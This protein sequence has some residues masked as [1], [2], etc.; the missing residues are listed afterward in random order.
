MRSS[1]RLIGCVVAAGVASVSADVVAPR[2]IL[3]APHAL[4]SD[5]TPD[6]AVPAE[7]TWHR[8]VHAGSTSVP[9][10]DVLITATLAR[11]PRLPKPAHVL[12]IPQ[13]VSIMASTEL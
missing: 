9:S 7:L 3:P 4:C 13:D 5:P 11:W 8:P 1:N 6:S 12:L 10:V 2:M